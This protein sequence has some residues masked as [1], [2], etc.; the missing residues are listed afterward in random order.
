M[1][2]R[3]VREEPV[4]QPAKQVWEAAAALAFAPHRL[5]LCHRA[6]LLRPSGGQNPHRDSDKGHAAVRQQLQLALHAPSVER[7][8][9]VVRHRRQ[10]K[11]PHTSK[12]AHFFFSAAQ[13][14]PAALRA[15]E[16]KLPEE[17]DNCFT[18]T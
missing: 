12:S 4:P 8:A 11:A 1:C 5:F 18:Y 14:T 7:D 2:F 3:G 15:S 6:A 13:K 9:T 10:E 17:C 16:A